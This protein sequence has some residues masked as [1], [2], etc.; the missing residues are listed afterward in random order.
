LKHPHILECYGFATIEGNDSIVL[1]LAEDGSLDKV[2][3]KFL[4]IYS[5]CFRNIALINNS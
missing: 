1:E 5:F 4:E 2:I 3:H